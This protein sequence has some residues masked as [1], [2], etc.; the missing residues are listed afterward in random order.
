MFVIVNCKCEYTLS[1][2]RILIGNFGRGRIVYNRDVGWYYRKIDR[3][4][5]DAMTVLRE[6]CG[7]T[8]KGSETKRRP[9][10]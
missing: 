6:Y 5:S 2:D 3:V 9:T 1:F 7:R 8:E 4:D 10:G